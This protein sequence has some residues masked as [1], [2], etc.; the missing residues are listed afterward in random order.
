MD[1][2]DVQQQLSGRAVEHEVVGEG[3]DRPVVAGLVVEVDSEYR[4][5]QRG[6][7][8]AGV[9]RHHQGAA[10]RQQVQAVHFRP[11][12]PFDKRSEQPD[13]ALGQAGVELR[14]F[15]NVDVGPGHGDPLSARLQPCLMPPSR[16]LVSRLTLKRSASHRTWY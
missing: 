7:L 2:A 5:I 6:V 14:D 13:H 10:A 4:P 3:V 12:I 9:I 15:R 16:R 1:A 8:A 11:E